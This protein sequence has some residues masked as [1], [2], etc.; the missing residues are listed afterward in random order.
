MTNQVITKEQY[1]TFRSFL[2]DASGI[3]LGDGKQYLVSSRLNRLLEEH[4]LGG[5]GELLEKLKQS[6]GILTGLRDK[7]VDAMTTNETN[8][9]R[10]SYPYEVLKQNILPALSKIR[11][12]PV[13]IWSSA[14]SSGQEPYSIGIIVQEFL[15]ANPGTFSGGIE[16]IATDISPTMLAYSRAGC[17]DDSAMARGLSEERKKRFFIK[18][19]NL[20]EIRPEIRKR[21]DFR[22][23][24]LKGSYTLLGRFDVIFCRNVL[25]YFSTELKSDILNR[26]SQILQPDGY[27]I[28]GSSEAPNRYTE[29]YSMERVGNGVIYR[30]NS[31]ASSI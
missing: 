19:G 30:R 1:D 13:K 3:L 22:P 27:L 4:K 14:C 15:L 10:D 9:F 25:I 7:V 11:D 16:I 17:Y 29:A 12:R 31:Q 8:W 23:L 21:V 28:L 20:W 26:M 2:E 6:D 5:F 24:N 18:S